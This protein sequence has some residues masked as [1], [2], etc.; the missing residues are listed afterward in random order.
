MIRQLRL[1]SGLVLFAYVGTHLLNH[2]LGIISLGA[3]E[4]GRL[5]FLAVWRNPVGTVLLYGSL[6][7]HVAL[8]LWT[9]YQARH[10]RLPRWEIVRLGLKSPVFQWRDRVTGEVVAE[11]DYGLLADESKHPYVIQLEQH[12]TVHV[13]LAEEAQGDVQ[14][15][16]GAPARAGK[17]LLAPLQGLADVVGH[18]DGGEQSDHHGLK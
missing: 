6:I 1:W 7:V 16:Q 3:A 4:S 17:A 9:L 8:V 12:K 11:F 15:F 14:G 10:L 5:V 2:S 18:G 13:A